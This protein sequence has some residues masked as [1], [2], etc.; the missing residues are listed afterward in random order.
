MNPLV[1]IIIPNYNKGELVRHSLESL[2]R[3]SFGDWEAVVVDDCSSDESWAIVQEYATQDRRIVAIRNDVNRGGNYSRNLGATMSKGKYIVFLDSDDWLSDD[4][5]ENRVQEFRR[6]KNRTV[7]LLVFPMASTMDGKTGRIWQSGNRKDALVGFLRHEI[8][9]S[10]MMPIWRRTA[11]ERVGGFDEVLP[12]LQDVELHTR[13][14]LMGLNYKFSKRKTPDCFY[15]TG[16]S[17]MTTNYEKA[18]E[19]LVNAVE[20]YVGK[21]KNLLVESPRSDVEK[22]HLLNALAETSLVALTN[23]GNL[24]QAGKIRREVRDVL[25]ERVTANGEK[26]WLNLFACLYKL[27]VNRMKGF[28]YLYRRIRRL[29][30]TWSHL[31]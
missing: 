24:Y 4:C 17:R 6:E 2:L 23:I 29:F 7:D 3:Q 1:S 9:W 20:M 13:A 26:R 19:T 18:A 10:I 15:F 21:M 12:R 22:R 8:P 14:L 28:N 30:Y 11:F 16:E 5:I 25:F 31:S 27:G